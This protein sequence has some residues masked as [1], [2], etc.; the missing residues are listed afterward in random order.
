[1]DL[2][3]LWYALLACGVTLLLCPVVLVAARRAGIL[4]MPSHRS[5]H[6]RPMP[7]AGG[8]APVVGALVALALVP[9]LSGDTR[10]ALAAA[11]GG[12]GCIGLIED[13]VGIRALVRLGLQVV[14]AGIALP[15]VLAGLHG[16]ILWQGAFV[17]GTILWLVAY[18]N[19]FNFMDG[20][21]GL[22]VAQAVVAGSAWYVLG[23]TEHVAGVAIGGAIVA[24]AAVGFAPFNL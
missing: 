8:V 3:T 9:G 18:T 24:G 11:G 5:S 7:R 20:I 17:V 23:R 6:D 22:S 10:A 12:F 19:A 4:D 1:M 14:A 16:S 21:D 13:V 15:W 2:M